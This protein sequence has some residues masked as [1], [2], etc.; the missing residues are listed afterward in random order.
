MRPSL[1]GL[2]VLA[3][4]V[5]A[6]GGALW[7][8]SAALRE[9]PPEIGGYVVAEPRP[10]PDVELRDEHG[11]AF[12]PASFAG[13]WSFLYFGYT[14]CPDVCPLTLIELATLKQ[15]LTAQM[16]A[17]RIDYYFVSVD[18][19]RDTPE[20]LREYVAYFD[21]GFRALTGTLEALTALATATS[22]LFYV[23]EGQAGDNYLVSHSSN[24]VLLS[25]AGRLAAV[26]T[27]PHK[28]PQLAADF[29]KIRGYY[30]AVR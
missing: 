26:L 16:P 3:V 6:A 10:L 27:P 11:G 8:T 1:R 2:L 18:P 29:A 19:R 20:R 12:T 5:A 30:E 25:P 13:A 23:P 17:E 7:L 24:I 4:A 14:Y 9:R 22:S 15:E 28:P 21:P